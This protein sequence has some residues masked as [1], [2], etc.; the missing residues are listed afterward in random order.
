[1]CAEAVENPPPTLRG[2]GYHRPWPG[3]KAQGESHV[4][5]EEWLQMTRAARKA[6]LGCV[7]MECC[8]VAPRRGETA[9]AGARSF[10]R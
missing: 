6:A 10:C 4:S 9:G 5:G 8:H 1:M 3:V 7:V 2:E